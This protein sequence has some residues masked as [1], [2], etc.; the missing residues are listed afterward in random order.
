M[1]KTVISVKLKFT[2][3]EAE[4][5]AKVL[6]EKY[7]QGGIVRLEDLCMMAIRREARPSKVS[8]I[9]LDVHKS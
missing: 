3:K 5:I 7:S 8:L 9:G 2:M 4:R 1:I 6:C